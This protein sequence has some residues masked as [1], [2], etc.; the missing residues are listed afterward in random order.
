MVQ[1]GK[2]RALAIWTAVVLICGLGGALAAASVSFPAWLGFGAGIMLSC[3]VAMQANMETPGNRSSG[4]V[5]P[6][7]G[8]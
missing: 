6:H 4:D 3:Y 7:V 8:W 1:P 5:P 2:R